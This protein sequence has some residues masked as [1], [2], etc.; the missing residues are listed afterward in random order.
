MELNNL[1]PAKGAVKQGKRIAR[2]Q[3][4]GTD[5]WGFWPENAGCGYKAWSQ[6]R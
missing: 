5:Q 4:S 6:G 3:G 2:G 1:K